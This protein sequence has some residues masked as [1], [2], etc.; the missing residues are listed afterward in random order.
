M[1]RLSACVLRET[2]LT[3]A[4]CGNGRCECVVYWTGPKD[5]KGMVDGWEHP[6]HRRSPY[7]YQVEDSWLTAY[8]F[9]LADENRS[10]RAQI[11][12]HPGEAFH[13]ATD[14]Q[15]PIVS[16][17]GFVSLVVPNFARGS[18]DLTQIWAGIL[19]KDGVWKQVPTTSI[20]EVL[21]E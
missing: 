12:T 17:E 14:D 1:L 21:N 16:T 6:A 3:L 2:V 5:E 8:W 18:I 13:S 4:W 15:W 20:L 10:I 19:D 7:G 9:R 11:H